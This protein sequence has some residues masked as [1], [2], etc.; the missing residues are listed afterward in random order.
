MI[1]DNQ[2]LLMAELDC[3]LLLVVFLEP[4]DDLWLSGGVSDTCPQ[5]SFRGSIQ[6]WKN[7]YIAS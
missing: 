7:W 6:E 5:M 3:F 2:T 4:F 1:K